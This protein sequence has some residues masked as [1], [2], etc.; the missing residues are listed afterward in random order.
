MQSSKRFI[1]RTLKLKVNDAKS[2]VARRRL[3]QVLGFSLGHGSKPTRR[4][5][6]AGPGAVQ[7]TGPGMTRRARGVSLEQR[8]KELSRYLQGWGGTSPSARLRR[9]FTT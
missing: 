3:A 8:V 9:C 6:P 4:I 2:A 5:A 7:E 1:T